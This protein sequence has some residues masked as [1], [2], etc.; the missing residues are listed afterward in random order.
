MNKTVYKHASGGIVFSDG[1]V[2]SIK[3]PAPYNEIVFPK[4]SIEKEETPEQAAVREVKEE[5]GYDVYVVAPI[6]TFSYEFDEDGKHFVK[7]LHYFI[8]ALKDKNQTPRHSRELHE[9]EEGFE[10]LWLTIK[11]ARKKLTHDNNKEMLGKALSIL[12][13]IDI[14]L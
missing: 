14:E 7:K 8:L 5:T 1:M 12:K 2:L 9:I 4:G 6:D 11:E 10:N 3:V 13:S